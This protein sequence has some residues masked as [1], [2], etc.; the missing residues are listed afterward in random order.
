MNDTRWLE[1]INQMD[2]LPP[3]DY[4]AGGI[5]YT[6]YLKDFLVMPDVNFGDAARSDQHLRSLLN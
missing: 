3:A 5:V 1:N 4:A 2:T 6:L